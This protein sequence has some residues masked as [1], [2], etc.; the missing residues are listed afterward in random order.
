MSTRGL[1]LF[2]LGLNVL[3]VAAHLR[4]PRHEQ[5]TPTLSP[6]SSVSPAKLEPQPP[7][8]EPLTVVRREVEPF[9]WSNVA[10]DDFDAYRD[11]LR[12]IGC[13][14]R[15]VREILVAE[16]NR[17]YAGRVSALL[18][19]LQGQFWSLAATAVFD[20]DAVEERLKPRIGALED[21]DRERRDLLK[22]L[23]GAPP[24]AQ[25]APP[26]TLTEHERKLVDFLTPEKQQLYADLQLEFA[27]ELQT[28][29]HEALSQG[30]NLTREQRELHR[31]RKEQALQTLFSPEEYFEYQLRTSSVAGLRN[32]QGLDLTEDELRDVAALRLRAQQAA[33]SDPVPGINDETRRLLM[34]RYGL[35]P[36]QVEPTLA[37][38]S[39]AEDSIRERIGDEAYAQLKRVESEGYRELWLLGRRT[40][41]PTT[42]VNQVFDIQQ[43]AR[44]HTQDA[45]RKG[46]WTPEQRAAAIDAIRIET[47]RTLREALPGQDFDNYSYAIGRWWEDL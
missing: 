43:V 10:S 2:A 27:T 9:Q 35:A 32:L 37:Q 38:S 34:E 15:T 29:S 24:P 30:N 12:A 42:T 19:D 28:L 40:G 16:V 4:L 5:P 36:E 31:K 44:S 25:P 8:A 39:A 47:E 14:D 45:Q 13:P 22:A 6:L 3:L 1:V 41:L 18:Q 7:V 21:L 26:Y 11:N 23:F 17:A 46:D 33:S 20:E